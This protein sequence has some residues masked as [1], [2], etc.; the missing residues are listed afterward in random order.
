MTACILTLGIAL[1]CGLDLW[2]KYYI[3]K[4][5]TDKEEREICGGKICLRKVHNKGMALNIGEKKPQVI[6]VISGIICMLISVNYVLLLGKNGKLLKKT[7]M[8][9]ILAGAFSNCYDRFVRKYVVDYFG[10]RTKWEK[11]SRITYNLGDIFLFL[12]SFLYLMAELFGGKR[13]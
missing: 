10:F 3:E 7:G 1:L 12:G 9:W 11:M 6:R 8:M 4:H 13:R 2:C 5:F